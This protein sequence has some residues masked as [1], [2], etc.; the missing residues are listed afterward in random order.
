MEHADRAGLGWGLAPSKDPVGQLIASWTSGWEI[1]GL[2][3]DLVKLRQEY[4]GDVNVQY[5]STPRGWRCER[6]ILLGAWMDMTLPPFCNLLS[7][8]VDLEK[9]PS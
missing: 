1:P 9:S 5:T 7:H 6:G 8:P 4:H 3:T 2:T